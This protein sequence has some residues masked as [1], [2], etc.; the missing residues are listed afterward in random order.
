MAKE[1]A[2]GSVGFIGPDNG[3]AVAPGDN[4]K[5]LAYSWGSV[6]ARAQLAPFNNVRKF[7]ELPYPALES[8]AFPF[9]AG[10]AIFGSTPILEFLHVFQDN[11]SGSYKSGPFEGYPREAANLLIYGLAAFRF[12]E[13]LAVGG[14]PREAYGAA[15]D[16]G[17][18]VHF[19]D[20]LAEVLGVRMIDR[21]HRDGFRVVIDCDVDRPS[22]G[23]FHSGA[24]PA[25][26]SE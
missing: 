4:E 18:D 6:V 16:D 21:V 14:K 8:L 13:V 19:P 12:A 7:A 20:T 3:L 24:R 5:A 2:L 26:T 17:R 11:N 23:L 25:A 15:G 10:L 9:E 22:E 1:I